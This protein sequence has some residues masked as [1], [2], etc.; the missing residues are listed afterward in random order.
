VT[1]RLAFLYPEMAL[2]VA[3]CVVMVVLPSLA[4]TV[5]GAPW[6]RKAPLK[7]SAVPLSTRRPCS[8]SR[9][10][11]P[12]TEGAR[13]SSGSLLR[14]AIATGSPPVQGRLAPARATSRLSPSAR[15]TPR[16]IWGASR[17][18]STRPERSSRPVSLSLRA[19]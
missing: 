9:G 6:L 18:A 7:P 17:R 11:P 2:F 3:T 16:A 12:S 19:R 10:P 8:S 13:P 14:L 4:T 5:R 15:G 1:D